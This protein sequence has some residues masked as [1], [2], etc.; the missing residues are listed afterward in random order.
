MH[1][2]PGMILERDRSCM[3]RAQIG[4]IQR[5]EGTCKEVIAGLVDSMIQPGLTMTRL[6]TADEIQSALIGGASDKLRVSE[7]SLLIAAARGD[8]QPGSA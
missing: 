4:M 7:C 1:Q 6:T 3:A 2:Q 5:W 8:S